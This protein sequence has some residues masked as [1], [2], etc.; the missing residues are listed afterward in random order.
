MPLIKKNLVFSKIIKKA[1]EIKWFFLIQLKVL[2]F[3]SKIFYF[4]YSSRNFWDLYSEAWRNLLASWTSIYLEKNIFYHSRYHLLTKFTMASQRSVV[5]TIPLV[6]RDQLLV[7]SRKILLLNI[8]RSKV[9]P[10]I[11]SSWPFRGCASFKAFSL[12]FKW[13]SFYKFH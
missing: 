2:N 7:T 11:C 4:V 12:L 9:Y 3:Y 8:I 10:S 13:P 1:I 5:I 6:G